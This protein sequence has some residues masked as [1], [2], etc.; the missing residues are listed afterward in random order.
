MVKKIDTIKLNS[1]DEIDQILGNPPG[2]ILRW[3]LTLVLV[4]V[5]IFL[6]ISWLIK[7]PDNI[8]APVVITTENPAIRVVSRISGKIDHLLVQDI[9]KVEKGEILA[10]LNAPASWQDVEALATLMEDIEEVKQPRDLININLVDY[11]RLGAMQNAYATISQKIKDLRYYL[12]QEGTL[13][14]IHSLENQ[15]EK[16]KQLSRAL[17]EQKKT[18]TQEMGLAYKNYQ[19]NKQLHEEGVIST[20][21]F[22]AIETN[23]LQYKRQL[24]NLDMQCINNE[25]SREQL[26]AQIL[27]LEQLRLDGVTNRMLSITE[28]RQRIESQ[29]DSWKQN[30]LIMAPI[31]GKVSM[32]KIWSEQQYVGA[33]QEVFTIVPG[34]GAGKII[35]KAN[36]P[37]AGSGKVQ[38]HQKANI[39]LDGFP[40][41]EFGV[42]QATVKQIAL[43]PQE[44]T[45][46]LEIELPEKLITT[47]GK[48]IPFRQELKGTANIVT[49]EKRIIHRIFEKIL[50]ILKNT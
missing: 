12:I 18:L 26:R 24:D 17:Q 44:D 19:R 34:G 22:E 25:V 6:V 38:L 11:W 50:N 15:I 46:A 27:E 23:Y 30:Y 14:K 3:G 35:G 29:I 41:Q 31:A 2:W 43:V 16:S 48:E 28:D 49:V 8:A 40:Y 36:L 32:S 13:N 4:A 37:V 1:G 39:S 42:I 47:Y 21:E 5:G 7:Y 10:I 33:N 9:Q 45:Y 20:I